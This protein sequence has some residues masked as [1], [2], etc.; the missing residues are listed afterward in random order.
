MNKNLL[1]DIENILLMGPGPSMVSDSVYK[2]LSVNTLGHLDPYFI[3]IMPCLLPSEPLFFLLIL[4][5]DEFL[6]VFLLARK[7]MKS[8]EIASLFSHG[9]D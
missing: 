8:L 1:N 4:C 6:V 3:D 9:Y 2:A 5:L 7:R